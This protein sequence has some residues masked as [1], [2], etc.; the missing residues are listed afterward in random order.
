MDI[1]RNS[2]LC[3]PKD[4][5]GLENIKNDLRR[6]LFNYMDNTYKELEFFYE[7]NDYILIPRYYNI[8]DKIIDKTIIG[9][10]IEIESNIIP[11]GEDQKEAIEFMSK[12]NCGI[13]KRATGTGKTVCAIATVCNVK[14]RTI[15]IVNQDELLDNWRSEFLLHTD[16]NSDQIEKLNSK[17][18]IDCFKKSVILATPQLIASAIN[19]PEFVKALENSNIGFMIVDEVHK[20]IGPEKFSLCSIYI[21]A[22]KTWGLSATPKRN[23]GCTDI[24]HY[25]LGPLYEFGHADNEIIDPEVYI[26]YF[27]HDTYSSHPKYIMWRGKF[28]HQRYAQQLKKSR[29][30]MNIVL[31]DIKR[32][33]DTNRNILVIASR[34]DILL[35]VAKELIIDKKYIGIFIPTTTKKERLKYS[36]TD[37]LKIAFKTKRIVFATYSGC[38]EGHSRKDLDC[39]F[40]LTPTPEAEQVCG[41]VVRSLDGKKTPII[42]DYVDTDPN[43]FQSSSHKPNEKTVFIKQS[44]KRLNFYESKN[45]KIKK[46]TF[47]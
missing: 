40:M 25:H 36:D 27:D 47:K 34:K 11:R 33:F 32:A 19:N 13:L 35:Q 6:K 21:N 15:I 23:D 20:A 39:L 1:V 30:F 45:W 28:I 37:D 7:K 4:Y 26:K 22:R 43:A 16:I 14:K 38:R 24:M 44:E 46:I 12:T 3:I 5:T 18:Y 29:K 17:N 10:D 2:G 31:N 9:A 42:V 41:R 8:E